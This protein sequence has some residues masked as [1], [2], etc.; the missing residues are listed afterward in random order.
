LKERANEL[1]SRGRSILEDD[2]WKDQFNAVWEQFKVLLDRVRNDS[3]TNQFGDQLKKLGHDLAFN[4][5]GYPDLFVM[6]DSLI[7][8][9]NLLIPLFKEQLAKVNIAK[10]EFSNDKYDVQISDIGFSGSFLPEHID[11]RMRNDS[12]LDTKNTNKDYMRHLLQFQVDNI[13][14]EFYN[15]KFNYRR[16]VFPKITDFGVADAKITG[17][18]GLIRVN[19]RVDVKGGCPPKA[20]LSEITCYID[21]LELHIVGEKTKHEILDAFLAPFFAK[22]IKDRIAQGIEDYLREKLTLVNDK[23]NEFLQSRPLEKLQEKENA[24]MQEQYKKTLESSKSVNAV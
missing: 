3:T 14:P 12:H 20:T 1:L 2:K 16:K 11:F 7:Q 4:E 9:K 10:I 24:F 6:E 5:K 17:S 22:N 18:G 15:F 21:K 19:W 13:K 8:I 23:L